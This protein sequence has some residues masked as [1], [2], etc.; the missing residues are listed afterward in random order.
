MEQETVK[1][2]FATAVPD[3]LEIPEPVLLSSGESAPSSD[4]GFTTKPTNFLGVDAN[5]V[6]GVFVG[7]VLHSFIADY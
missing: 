5:I 3:E 4:I 7:M 2:I 6:F 1:D